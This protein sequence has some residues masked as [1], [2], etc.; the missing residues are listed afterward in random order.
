MTLLSNN[1]HLLKLGHMLSQC[2]RI[3][4]LTF[5]LFFLVLWKP[6]EMHGQDAQTQYELGLQ[7]YYGD[8]VGQNRSHAAWLFLQA[9]NQG[10]AYSQYNLGF[11]YEMGHGV[12]QSYTEAVYW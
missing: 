9:A 11:M 4:P 2:F 12:S 8:G 7:Y 6:M 5:G 1:S 3:W 10:H